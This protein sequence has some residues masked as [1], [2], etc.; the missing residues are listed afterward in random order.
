[1]ST[2]VTACCLSWLAGRRAHRH[3]FNTD[4][5]I[6]LY[7]NI[8]ATATTNSVSPPH[9]QRL[10]ANVVVSKRTD[11]PGNGKHKIQHEGSVSGIPRA[12]SKLEVNSK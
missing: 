3:S 4:R 9:H 6:H 7:Q 12:A 1:M 10:P 5:E 8:K 11:S 2:L